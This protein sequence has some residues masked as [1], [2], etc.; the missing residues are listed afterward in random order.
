MN[1]EENATGCDSSQKTFVFDNRTV[2]AAVIL[3]FKKDMSKH[4]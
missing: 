4:F 1:N 3:G 2:R